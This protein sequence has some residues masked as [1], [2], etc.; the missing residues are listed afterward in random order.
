MSD[1]GPGLSIDHRRGCTRPIVPS[2]GAARSDRRIASWAQ[3]CRRCPAMSRRLARHPGRTGALLYA[4]PR[5]RRRRRR[6]DRQPGVARTPTQPAA[7]RAAT[8]RRTDH[9]DRQPHELRRRR[10]ARAGVPAPRTLAAL[11]GHVGRVPRAGARPRLL[12]GSGSFRSPAAGRTRPPPS[13]RRRT[14]SPP[15]RRSAS[16]PRAGSPA[17]RT[18]GPSARRPAP[19]G[20]RC[21]P[22]RRSSRWRWSAP[23]TSSSRKRIVFRLLKNLVLRPRVDVLVGDADRRARPRRRNVDDPPPEA[24]RRAADLVMGELV[25]LVAERPPSST[26]ST[27]SVCHVWTNRARVE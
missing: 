6:D 19:C 15:A 17:I 24:V 21:G 13:M 8:A 20:W 16:F 1:C 27:P 25:G 5:R 7:R 23:T 22:A 18:A 26:P 2:T 3:V 9:R 10:P 4:A 12:D 11:L 14:R